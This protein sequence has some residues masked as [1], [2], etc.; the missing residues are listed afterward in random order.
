MRL[1]CLFY[2]RYAV[3]EVKEMP[4]YK[5]RKW[6]WDMEWQQRE[7]HDEITTISGI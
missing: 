3:D 2:T 1:M 7:H 4:E 6:Y 5:M